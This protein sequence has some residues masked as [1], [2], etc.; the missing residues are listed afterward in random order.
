M[1]LAFYRHPL[2]RNVIAA[3]HDLLMA[4][5]SFLIAVWLRLGAGMFDYISGNLVTP[6]VIFMAIAMPVFVMN[7][8]Y[9]GLWRFA[10][11]QDLIVL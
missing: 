6:T 4:G 8:L 9:R 5:L 3:L 7:R 11:V 10:S 1:F 2:N